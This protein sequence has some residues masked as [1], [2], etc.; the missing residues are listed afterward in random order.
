[1]KSYTGDVLL[2][3]TVH[4][5]SEKVVSGSTIYFGDHVDPFD[6]E[7]RT[8][9]GVV[10]SAPIK[11]FHPDNMLEIPVDVVNGDVV[12]THHF[13]T[14]EMHEMHEDV[15]WINYAQLICKETSGGIEML[16]DYNLVEW[17]DV[18]EVDDDNGRK[19][20]MGVLAVVNKAML[21]MGVQPGSRILFRP[22]SEYEI[23]VKDQKYYRI[24]NEHIYALV[25]DGSYKPL[26]NMLLVRDG[27]PMTSFN[28][29]EVG[30]KSRKPQLARIIDRGPH[31]SLDGEGLLYAEG[32]A[33]EIPS[34]DLSLVKERMV[35]CG[36]AL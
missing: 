13:L 9:K 27:E 31:S 30:N 4:E 5:R 2:N 35:F 8:Q 22:G 21:E 18:N 36:V 14:H 12:Y 29:I 28:G 34:S 1:M 17:I 19:P 3:V 32:T 26:H 25:L 7:S 16:N 33:V 15:R 10:V 23:E 11:A 6:E 24:Y 20:L